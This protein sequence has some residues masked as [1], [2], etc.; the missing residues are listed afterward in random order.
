MYG[1]PGEKG[2]LTEVVRLFESPKDGDPVLICADTLFTVVGNP[3][4]FVFRENEPDAVLELK[5][6]STAVKVPRD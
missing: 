6:R 1:K 5:I 2:V 3:L 4:I